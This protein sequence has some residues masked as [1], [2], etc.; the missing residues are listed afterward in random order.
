MADYG[1]PEEVATDVVEMAMAVYL[2]VTTD[3]RLGRW[4]TDG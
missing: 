1:K 3:G 2:L 4:L